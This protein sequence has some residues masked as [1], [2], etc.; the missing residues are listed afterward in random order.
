VNTAESVTIFAPSDAAFTAADWETLDVDTL[1]AVLKYHVVPAVAFSNE[2]TDGQKLPTLNGEE[3]TVSIADGVVKVGGATV[4]A[5]NVIT[6]TGVVHLIDAVMLP[7]APAAP[8]AA[9]SSASTLAI[10]STL[11]AAVLMSLMQ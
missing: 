4:T 10:G 11:V 5:A 2:L 1:S 8:T 7:P 9:D 6:K 3:L